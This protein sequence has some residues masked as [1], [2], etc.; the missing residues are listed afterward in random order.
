MFIV[1]TIFIIFIGETKTHFLPSLKKTLRRRTHHHYIIIIIISINIINSTWKNIAM[2]V[3]VPII[4]VTILIFLIRILI[5]VIML[6]AVFIILIIFID[7][8]SII[9]TIDTDFVCV[10]KRQISPLS[11]VRIGC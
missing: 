3:I 11:L 7:I 10:N 5:S 2:A 1:F 4:T 9:V 6:P 8:I